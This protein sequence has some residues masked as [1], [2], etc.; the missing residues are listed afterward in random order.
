MS[1][2][3]IDRAQKLEQADALAE[4]LQS[5]LNPVKARPEFV[6]RLKTNLVNEP[7]ISVEYRSRAA[8]FIIIAAGL[9]T[10]ALLT[11]IMFRLRSI[12][13]RRRMARY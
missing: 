3:R 1:Y 6:Q 10:G 11:W 5:A 9:F 12:F 13:S 4:R 2:Q 8:A 7:A